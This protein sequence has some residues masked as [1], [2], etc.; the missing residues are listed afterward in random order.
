MHTTNKYK[1]SATKANDWWAAR[2]WVCGFNFLPSTAVNF[3]EMWMADT[4][5]RETIARELQWAADIGFNSVRTNL[6]YLVW[7]ND[8]EGLI[9]RFEWFLET[10][11][12]AGLDTMPVL[13]DDCGFGGFEPVYGAQPEPAKNIHNGRAVANP[14]RAAVMDRTQWPDFKRYVQDVITRHKDDTRV[15]LWD[16]YNEPGN[17]MIFTELGA[18]AEFD[19]AMTEHSRDLMLATFEWTREI[20][21]AQPLTVAAWRTPPPG[22]D[23]RAY[24]NEIDRLAIELSDVITF[25]AYCNRNDAEVYI[26]QLSEIGRPML[27]TEWMARTIDSKISDQLELYHDRKVGC[28]NWGLVQG[29][30]Q[31]HLPWPHTLEELHGEVIDENAWFHDVLRPDGSPYDETETKL[32]SGLTTPKSGTDLGG[33]QCRA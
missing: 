28:F 19:H 2:P 31:T 18:F 22:Y 3:L 15:L 5:D 8:Q 27:T 17:L 7:K 30:T 1:W 14:G 11:A 23:A 26:D 12:K 25:H 20:N 4:F 13:F 32:I 9:E 24:D 29:R 10:A 6:H 16:L 21:P 33:K